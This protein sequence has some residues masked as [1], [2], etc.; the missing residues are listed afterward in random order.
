MADARFGVE[1][2]LVQPGL[3]LKSLNDFEHYAT[4]KFFKIFVISTN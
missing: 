4:L 3:F 1:H 2:Q